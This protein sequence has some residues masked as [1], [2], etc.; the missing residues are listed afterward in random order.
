MALGVL[1]ILA[2][3]ADQTRQALWAAKGTETRHL[4]ET[5]YSL[6]ADFMARAQAVK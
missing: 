2:F 6:V 3:S 4:V 5:A 1:G